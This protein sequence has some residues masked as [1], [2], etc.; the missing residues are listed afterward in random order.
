MVVIV[1]LTWADKASQ[2]FWSHVLTMERMIRSVAC[3]LVI[4]ILF[5]FCSMPRFW[6]SFEFSATDV[7]TYGG[8][9]AYIAACLMGGSIYDARSLADV[10]ISIYIRCVGVPTLVHICFFILVVLTF[11][12]E[13]DL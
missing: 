4:F 10:S 9:G 2:L 3:P 11:S 7:S 5:L 6:S 13:D 8:Q 1:D 12:S